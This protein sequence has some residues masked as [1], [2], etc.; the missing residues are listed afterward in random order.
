MKK[1]IFR[2]AL[3]AFDKTNQQADSEPPTEPEPELP[4]TMVSH[5]RKKIMTFERLRMFV[6]EAPI[7]PIQ[8]HVLDA[9]QKKINRKYWTKKEHKLLIKRLFDE[10]TVQYEE[11]MKKTNGSLCLTLKIRNTELS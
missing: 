3:G 10:V 6:N 9:I 4:S 8:P 1:L 7:V 2:R 11:S 5:N